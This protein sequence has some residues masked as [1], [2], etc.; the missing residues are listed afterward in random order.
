MAHPIFLVRHRLPLGLRNLLQPNQS[1]DMSIG[2]TRFFF[3][4]KNH[5][6]LLGWSFCSLEM[7]RQLLARQRAKPR[8]SGSELA[9]TAKKRWQSHH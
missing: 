7:G 9:K 3:R 5:G 4:P 1:G 8:W 2:F 6:H